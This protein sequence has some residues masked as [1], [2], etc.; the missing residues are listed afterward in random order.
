MLEEP[1]EIIR[2]ANECIKTLKWV[3]K[4]NLWLDCKTFLIIE[5]AYLLQSCVKKIIHNRSC[6][7]VGASNKKLDLS[8]FLPEELESLIKAINRVHKQ[9]YKANL[10]HV[11]MDF[12]QD[13]FLVLMSSL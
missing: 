11:A 7:V 8:K 10:P 2:E 9:F 5:L 1:L 12:C 3:R 13:L 6:V 4:G